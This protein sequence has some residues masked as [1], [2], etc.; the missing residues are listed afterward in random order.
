MELG[1]E[2]GLSPTTVANWVRVADKGDA[3]PVAGE[4]EAESDKARI[5]RLE[6]ELARREEEQPIPES[7]SV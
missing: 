4:G 1:K 3:A 5:A 7:R 6:R 2:F